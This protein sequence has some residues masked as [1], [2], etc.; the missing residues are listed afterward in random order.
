MPIKN[1]AFF[2][3]VD[4]FPP[5]KFKLIGEY[6]GKKLL[7]VGR[8]K[9]YGDPIVATSQTDEPS[10]EDLY[11]SDL[12]ELMKFSHEPV[13]VTEEVCNNREPCSIS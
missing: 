4:F 9:A 7:L 12:Y 5:C 8:A 1:R 10:Q 3:Y 13:K 2:S 6:A 11:A